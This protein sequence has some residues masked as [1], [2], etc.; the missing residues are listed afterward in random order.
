[1]A[2]SNQYA[3]SP[4]HGA[5]YNAE[6]P[7]LV[8]RWPKPLP[9]LIAPAKG[10]KGHAE[11]AWISSGIVYRPKVVTN[12]STNHRNRAQCGVTNTVNTMP[13]QQKTWKSMTLNTVKLSNKNACYL[14]TENF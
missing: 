9:V 5:Q 2:D 3:S 12:P 11:W 4:G 13:N 7:F 6:L 10:D 14:I 8:Q 1:M